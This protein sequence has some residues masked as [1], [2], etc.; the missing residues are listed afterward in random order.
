LSDHMPVFAEFRQTGF[1][2]MNLKENN[3]L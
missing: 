1:D 3:L 2:E